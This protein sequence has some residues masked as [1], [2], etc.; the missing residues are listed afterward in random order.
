MRKSFLVIVLFLIA[1]FLADHY[2]P[3]SFLHDWKYI[4]LLFFAALSYVFH[5]IINTSKASESDNFIQFYLSTVLIRLLA[6]AIFIT[7]A[8]YIKVENRGLF[9]INFFALYLFFTLFEILGLYRT[10]RRF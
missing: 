6:C 1:F 4:I 5:S 3:M 9:I 8:L 2:G 10:L 7:V